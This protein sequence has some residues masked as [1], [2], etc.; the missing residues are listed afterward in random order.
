MNKP[1]HRVKPNMSF[2]QNFLSDEF[3][4]TVKF[5]KK[6][7]YKENKEFFKNLQKKLLNKKI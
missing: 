2:K 7:Q 4:K 3:D 5:L 6:K 1:D